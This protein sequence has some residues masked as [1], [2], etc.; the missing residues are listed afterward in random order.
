M[1]IGQKYLNFGALIGSFAVGQGSLFFAQSYLVVSDNLHLLAKFGTSFSVL[2]LAVMLVDFGY[3]TLLA[4][5]A[6]HEDS[7]ELAQ[8]YTS[9]VIVRLTIAGTIAAAFLITFRLGGQDNFFVDY[10]GWA[11]AGVFAWSFNC[12]GILDGKRVSAVNGLS[13]TLPYLFSATALVFAKFVDEKSAARLT[14][15]ALASGYICA[16]IVQILYLTKLDMM[17][18]LYRPRLRVIIKS[19]TNAGSSLASIISPQLYFRAQL[20]ISAFFLPP[21][22]T[23]LLVYTKQITASASQISAFLRRVGFPDLV[24]LMRTESATLKGVLSTQT[25]AI[26][27]ALAGALFAA[28]G[29]GLLSALAIGAPSEAGRAIAL[30]A[31]AIALEALALALTQALSAAGRFHSAAL[32]TAGALSGGL[33]A[34][35]IAVKELHFYSFMMADAIAYAMLIALAAI[36]IRSFTDH[37]ASK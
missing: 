24:A 13:S 5:A 36:Q 15:G 19:A 27:I 29:G 37:A 28:L 30:F 34:N 32:S 4:K 23:A 33:L 9:A 31:P 18:S 10:S 25:P 3:S 26:A 22:A 7:I 35:Y 1:K 17:P 2:I 16:V 8:Q 21:Q 6:S 14:G 11:F 20:A 12:T